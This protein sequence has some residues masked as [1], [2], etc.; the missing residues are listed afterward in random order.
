MPYWLKKADFGQLYPCS[1][2][3]HAVCVRG[4]GESRCGRGQ[5]ESGVDRGSIWLA[6][7]L[8]CAHGGPG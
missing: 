5:V 7:W 3:E 4:L 6:L 1:R 8:A 2:A